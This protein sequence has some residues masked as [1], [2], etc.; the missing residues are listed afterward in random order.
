MPTSAHG[1]LPPRT[2]KDPW[3]SSIGDMH[4]IWRLICLATTSKV[5][6][7]P[8]LV[9]LGSCVATSL[10]RPPRLEARH[11]APEEPVPG[12]YCQQILPCIAKLRR[13]C[14]NLG[15][16]DLIVVA[17]PGLM[18]VRSIIIPG[19]GK[20]KARSRPSAQPAARSPQAKMAGQA[21]RSAV[22][23]G[24]LGA[25]WAGLR[26]GRYRAGGSRTADARL[27][28]RGA[29]GAGAS[30]PRIKATGTG[31]SIITPARGSP[32]RRPPKPPGFDYGRSSWATPTNMPCRPSASAVLG[33][34]H[35]A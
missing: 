12:E 26:G 14:P 10:P 30:G 32:Q 33:A 8:A 35:P 15:G 6:V 24:G 28:G 34:S 29:A 5:T 7:R 31:G 4:P 11:G 18:W 16:V 1:K 22:G 27:R 25:L 19:T 13:P 3:G 20:L 23:R 21:A 2:R 9:R 17:S